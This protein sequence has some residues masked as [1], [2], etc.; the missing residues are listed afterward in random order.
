MITIYS[1]DNCSQCFMIQKLC[2]RKKLDHQI[3]KL[4]VDFSQDDMISLTEGKARSYPQVFNGEEY[5]GDFT[6][7]Q[8]FVAKL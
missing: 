3:K 1:K 6:A 5:V 8:K 7:A 2:E 4:D